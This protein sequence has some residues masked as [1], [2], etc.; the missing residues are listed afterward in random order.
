MPGAGMT[1]ERAAWEFLGIEPE[2]GK[3]ERKA[4]AKGGARN[5]ETPEGTGGLRTSAHAYGDKQSFPLPHSEGVE[6]SIPPAKAEGKTD[7]TKERQKPEAPLASLA[8]RGK[9]ERRRESALRARNDVAILRRAAGV[10]ETGA[11]DAAQW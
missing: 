10:P 3:E 4:A 8:A 7:G 11:L 9:Q 1:Q 2:T 5:K 6:T